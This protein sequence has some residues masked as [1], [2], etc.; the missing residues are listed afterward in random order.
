MEVICIR[1]LR[2][3]ALIRVPG[4]EDLLALLDLQ[5]VAIHGLVV[6]ERESQ[7]RV[8]VFGLQEAAEVIV[9]GRDLLVV[10]AGLALVSKDLAREV[11]LRG[12]YRVDFA[13]FGIDLRGVVGVAVRLVLF[14]QGVKIVVVD[15]AVF[16]GLHLLE[17]LR[18][19][20]LDQLLAVL[21]ELRLVLQLDLVAEL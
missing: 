4:F 16:F 1:R 14:Q 13:D 18:V 3:V 20:V 6:E 12:G 19:A 15:E 21:V 9:D 10:E 8:I 2:V 7:V 17:F 11:V 5:L